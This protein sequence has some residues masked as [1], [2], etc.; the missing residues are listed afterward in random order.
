MGFN[1][2]GEFD[3]N[4]P[5]DA[6]SLK[7]RAQQ[8]IGKSVGRTSVGKVLADAQ[9]K[10]KLDNLSYPNDLFSNRMVYGGNYVVFYVNVPTESKLI[11]ENRVETVDIDNSETF[12]AEINRQGYG[13]AAAVGGSALVG[14]LGGTILGALGGGAGGAAGGGLVGAGLGAL[15][16]GVVS[17]AVGGKMS[18]QVRRL[19]SAI[20]LHVPNQLSTTY[21][22]Q[23]DTEDTGLFQI[24]AKLGEAGVK[25]IAD[26]DPKKLQEA[27]GVLGS[28]AVGLALNAPGGGALSAMSGLAYNPK[29]EQVFKGVDFRTFTFDYQ[30]SPRDEKEL[31]NVKNIIKMFKI[32]MHPEFKDENSFL[33][34]YPSEFD[35][36]YYKDLDQNKALFK[37]TSCVLTNLTVNYTPNAAFN[38][39]ADGSPTQVNIQMTFKELAMLTKKEIE[40]GF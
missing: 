32:H 37:H 34:I 21:S 36:F 6:G 11:S 22:T 13:T 18:R 24:G 33:Y 15:A 7:T 26:L 19:K 38:T 23:W 17:A 5:L 16:G 30:F 1:A 39:F 12:R 28:A 27:G 2:F 31:E 10:Y 20:A 35:I 29:K 8:E 3:P 9:S 25:A 4:I 14:G 40:E